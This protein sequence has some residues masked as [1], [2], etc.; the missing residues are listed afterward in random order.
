M[1]ALAVAVLL[2][3]ALVASAAAAAA[4]DVV[5]DAVY[6]RSQLDPVSA[7][8]MNECGSVSIRVK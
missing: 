8:L 5:S 1:E 3:A 7:R 4:I 2:A 6:H